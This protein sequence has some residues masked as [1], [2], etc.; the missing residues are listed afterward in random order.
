MV[1]SPQALGNDTLD[2]WH[3]ADQQSEQLSFTLCTTP[4]QFV[5]GEQG[6]AVPSTSTL[7]TSMPEQSL[8]WPFSR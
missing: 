2:I 1:E 7:V 6:R 5:T 4:L 3:L 8:Y